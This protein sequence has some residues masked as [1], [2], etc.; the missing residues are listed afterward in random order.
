MGKSQKKATK[1]QSKQDSKRNHLRFDLG[2]NPYKLTV[3]FFSKIGKVGKAFLFICLFVLLTGVFCYPST[4]TFYN[5]TRNTEKLAIELSALNDRNATLKSNVD[6]LNTDQGIEDKAKSDY[7][8]VK[9]G[10]GSAL[11]QGIERS[12]ENNLPKFVDVD[13]IKADGSWFTPFLDL[14]FGYED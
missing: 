10:E 3:H 11:V 14:I 5:E 1:I 9:N 6:A 7:G 2:F 8:Y 13:D 12:K 4:K